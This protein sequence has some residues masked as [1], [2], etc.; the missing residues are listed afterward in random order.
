MAEEVLREA[1][2]RAT[3]M[4]AAAKKEAATILDAARFTAREE[5][6]RE[7]KEAQVKGWRA[8]EEVMAK[9]RIEVKKVA[10]Q[11]RE[12]VMNEVF[13]EAEEKLRKYAA[14]N[15][16]RGDLVR[17]AI[18]SCKKLGTGQVLI[19]ANERDLRVLRR[20]RARI[21][22]ALLVEVAG[23]SFGEPIQAIGGVRVTS[24]DGRIEIDDTFDCRLRRELD[25]M[26][27][28]VARLLFGS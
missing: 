2:E 18:G 26:R 5:E 19:S 8:Y 10:L 7:L 9:G 27:V 1:S 23:V 24:A 14:S 6:A 22:R 21:A 20:A 3:A 25:V 15:K 17:L 16:Y 4:I 13:R 28:K 12:E 11:R